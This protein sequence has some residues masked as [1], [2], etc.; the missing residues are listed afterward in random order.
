MTSILNQ[1]TRVDEDEIEDLVV[2]LLDTRRTISVGFLNQYGYNLIEKNRQTRDSFFQLDYLL[3]DG[4]GIEIACRYHKLEPKAN[5]NGTDFIPLLISSALKSNKQLRFFAYG[6]CEPWLKTG[7]KNLFRSRD[8]LSLDGFLSESDYVQHYLRHVD[9]NR[10]NI[11][12]LA[13]GMPKQ[14]R[15]AQLIKEASDA[16]T[17]IVC[18]GAIIDFQAGRFT[19]APEIFQQ[20]GLEW[21]YRLFLEPKRLFKRYVIGIPVFIYNVMYC[22]K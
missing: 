20:M 15:V 2:E 13:M 18:G 10:L 11:I 19:R 7:A 22:G 16:P 17:I 6:T 9:E 5:L 1:L 4:K 3:R 12:V 14:E 8:F 21:L